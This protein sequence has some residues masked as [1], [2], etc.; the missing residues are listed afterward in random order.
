VASE[1]GAGGLAVKG[2]GWW[3]SGEGGLARVGRGSKLAAGGISQQGQKAVVAGMARTGMD[4]DSQPVAGRTRKAGQQ[5]Q[6]NSRMWGK[7]RTM[8]EDKPD[9]L[10]DWDGQRKYR[11]WG[12]RLLGTKGRNLEVK[13]PRLEV[14]EGQRGTVTCKQG[15]GLVGGG[16][17][18]GRG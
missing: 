8:G 11:P 12:E 9:G 4:Q 5:K 2:W 18:E 13:K 17:R 14:A 16:Q 3:G 6:H 10:I 7:G 1:N 15:G